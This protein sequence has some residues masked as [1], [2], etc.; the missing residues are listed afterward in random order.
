MPQLN[1]TYTRV[2]KRLCDLCVNPVTCLPGQAWGSD[3]AQLPGLV[4]KLSSHFHNDTSSALLAMH[5]A[6][7][8]STNLY[9]RTD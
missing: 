3:C 5:V 2:Y 9:L 6:A 1:S 7:K 4:D 8:Q